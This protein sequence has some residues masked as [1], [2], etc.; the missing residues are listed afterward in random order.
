MGTPY[1]KQEFA[2]SDD[3]QKGTGFRQLDR[4]VE[5]QQRDVGSDPQAL[6]LPGEPM[7]QRQLWKEVEARGDVVLAGPDRVKPERTNQAHLLQRFV[8]T[9]GRII[10]CGVLRVQIDTK[11]HCHASPRRTVFGHD[12]ITSRDTFVHGLLAPSI[13]GPVCPRRF[14]WSQIRKSRP[15]FDHRLNCRAFDLGQIVGC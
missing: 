12:G 11:L 13:R 10:A 15:P 5:R 14:V 9:T 4:I 2:A 6:G 3:V 1:I 7:Q 8:E